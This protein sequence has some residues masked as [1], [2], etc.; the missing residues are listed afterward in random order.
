MPA[1]NN[2]ETTVI[3]SNIATA[4]PPTF[5]FPDIF[6]KSRPSMTTNSK[7]TIHSPLGLPITLSPLTN[8]SVTISITPSKC[9]LSSQFGLASTTF[10]R[11]ACSFSRLAH[12][13]SSL[14]HYVFHCY[15]IKHFSL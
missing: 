1:P 4:F 3:S 13:S 10:L 7:Y 12:S 6:D 9:V 5:W 14:L 15:F 11:K 8:P 2:Q